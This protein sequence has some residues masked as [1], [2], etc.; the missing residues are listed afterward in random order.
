MVFMAR[1]KYYAGPV[2]DHFDGTR[3]FNPGQPSTDRSLRDLWRWRRTSHRAQWPDSVPITTAVPEKSVDALRITMVGHATVLIQAAGLNILTDPVWS[4]RASP[5]R[6]AGPKRVNAPGVAFENLPPIDALLI[7]HN[8]YDHLDLVTLRRLQAEHNPLMIMPLG[9]DRI[10]KKA[11]PQA[12]I[13]TGDWYDR[14]VIT[15][16]LSVTLTPAYHWSARGIFDRRM[17]LWAG[18]WLNIRGQKLWFAGDTAYGDGTLFRALHT[19]YGAPDVAIIPIGAYEPRWFMAGQ[20]VNPHEAVCIYKDTQAK[21]AIGIH[22]GTFQLTDE[23]IR[24]PEKALQAALLAGN[25]NVERFRAASPGLVYQF[26]G[27]QE[28]DP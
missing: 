14:H 11:T 19:R 25:C 21:Q 1:N 2:T 26:G 4:E 6:W 13:L 15:P 23:G 10:V 5:L 8:H 12:R 7:S 28:S 9:N 18:F 3:F 17:A 27:S 22:W 24:A 16:A 20:H